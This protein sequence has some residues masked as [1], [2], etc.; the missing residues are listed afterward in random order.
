MIEV[1]T[2][3]ENVYLTSLT[4]VKVELA[5]SFGDDDDLL[6]DL[7]AESSE[8]IHAWLGRPLYR[9]EYRESR[10]G[11]GTDRLVLGRYPAVKLTSV[12]LDGSNVTSDCTLLKESGTLAKSS[13]NFAFESGGVFG[14]SGS[15]VAWV[16][17]YTAGYFLT[18]DDF[19]GSCSASSSDN[20]Y[21]SSALFHPFLV[22]GDIILADGFTNA[23]NNGYKTVV[24]ATTSKIVVNATLVTESAGSR[25]LGMRNLPGHYERACIDLVRM[26]YQARAVSPSVK[27]ISVGP[28]SVTYDTNASL[29]DIRRRVVGFSGL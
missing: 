2:A 28:A 1:I 12:L 19:S 5:I 23:A 15:A 16:I 17:T 24:S 26:S 20:S 6:S 22:A 9:A 29:L 7:I 25:T 18:D 11:S 3:P 14:A 21:N 10:A 8:T 13:S 27:S 4:R